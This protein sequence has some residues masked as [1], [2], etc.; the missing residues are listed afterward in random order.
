MNLISQDMPNFSFYA[1]I[2]FSSFSIFFE[3]GIFFY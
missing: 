1:I 3:G 2:V